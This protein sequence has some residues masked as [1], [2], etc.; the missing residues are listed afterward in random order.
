MW[1]FKLVVNKW[2]HYEYWPWVLFYLP[3]LPY[4]LYLSIKARS[5]TYFTAVNPGF[6]LGGL[7]GESKHDI[8]ELIPKAF[9]PLTCYFEASVSTNNVVTKCQS[10][11]IYFPFIIKPDVGERGNGVEKINDIQ[12]LEAYL[13]S[14]QVSFLIQEY[15]T[16]SLEFGVFYYKMPDG[17]NSGVTSITGKE[18]LKVT[19]DGIAT[20]EQLVRRSLRASYQYNRLSIKFKNRW[21]VVVALGEE[22]LL[23]T[24][25]NHSRGTMFLDFKQLNTIEVSKIFDVITQDIN[26]FYYGRFDLKATSYESLST[27]IGLKIMEL[28]GV[29]SEPAHVYDP[30]YNVFK[31]YKDVFYH[32]KLANLIA[33]QNYKLGSERVPFFY[34]LKQL[35]EYFK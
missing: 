14:N 18:F 2:F 16:H 24:I 28:N 27:G 12:E 19:G 26:G 4:Y 35:I 15:L 7:F 5:F 31:A 17:S 29:S 8:L 9:L 22:I 30:R 3:C 21:N 13:E 34:L 33:K 11:G 10:L 32:M 1:K 20:L 6:Y 25:G 23:E